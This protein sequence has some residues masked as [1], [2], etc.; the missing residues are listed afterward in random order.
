MRVVGSIGAGSLPWALA[1][2]LLVVGIAAVLPALL[3][4][5]LRAVPT[6]PQVI[7]DTLGRVADR[8]A[9]RG[10]TLLV[11]SGG[12]DEARGAFS[13]R[14]FMGRDLVFLGSQTLAELSGVELRSVLAHELGHGRKSHGMWYLAL[15][16]DAIWSAGLLARWLEPLG[17]GA[18][19]AVLIGFST[20]VFGGALPLIARRFE[21]EADLE[22]A[23]AVGWA[24][25]TC[26]ISSIG[27][28]TP[29]NTRR[30]TLL[31]PSLERRLQNLD[32]WAQS[33]G[34]RRRF[35]WSSATIRVVLVGWL[36]LAG[37][38]FFLT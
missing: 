24:D 26:A 20:L 7:C 29:H 15:L 36:A 5:A 37:V 23:Q 16:I 19:L 31:H 34:R 30:A 12:T 17:N 11:W 33:P 27:K 13:A 8:L 21:L 35:A 6:P 10:L 9:P 25:Y 14:R 3:R 32:D 38:S 18:A 22:A 2:L 1:V 4:W 28:R